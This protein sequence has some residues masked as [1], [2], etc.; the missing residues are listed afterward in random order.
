MSWGLPWALLFYD[1]C[2]VFIYF[3][4]LFF[5]F[6]IY[7]LIIHMILLIFIYFIDLFYDLCYIMVLCH[8]MFSILCHLCW[9]PESLWPDQMDCR[10]TIF[11]LMSLASISTPST[12]QSISFCLPQV[13]ALHRQCSRASPSCVSA[14]VRCRSLLPQRWPE[15][16]APCSHC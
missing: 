9:V 4:Y 13:S 2:Y 5:I 16:W 14:L 7:V 10:E 1:L 12:D 15:I 3:M 8:S 11:F 6:Y